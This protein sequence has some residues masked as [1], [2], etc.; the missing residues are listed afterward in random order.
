M[1]GLDLLLG[2]AV[3]ALL[4]ALLPKSTTP[5][6]VTADNSADITAPRPSGARKRAVCIGINYIGTENQLEGCINDAQSMQACLL[7]MYGA[8]KVIVLT[9]LTEK[10]PTRDNIL[11]AMHWLVLGAGPGDQLVLHYSGHGSQLPDS[12]GNELSGEHSVIVPLDF[13]TRGFLSD[14]DLYQALVVPLNNS[15]ARF[16]VVYDCCFS[17]TDLNLPYGYLSTGPVQTENHP[18]KYTLN[19]DVVYLGACLDSEVDADIEN[20]QTG[21]SYGIL[22]HSLLLALKANRDISYQALMAEIDQDYDTA[23]V[24]QHVEIGSMQSLNLAEPFRL[25]T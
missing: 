7:D 2:L 5:I 23:Q 1:I 24:T 13:E 8:D 14:D 16:R 11:Q 25:M 12:T 4:F 6:R 18:E 15:G 20:T 22:T 21:D 19:A 3:V 17:G 9:D 10:Q